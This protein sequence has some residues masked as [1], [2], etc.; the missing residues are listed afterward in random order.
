M[1][2]FHGDPT[3]PLS[4]NM[5][6]VTPQTRIDAYKVFL[7]PTAAVSSHLPLSPLPPPVVHL[8]L[9]QSPAWRLLPPLLLSFF[10]HRFS[11]YSPSLCVS[12]SLPRNLA[13]YPLYSPFDIIILFLQHLYL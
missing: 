8:S 6:V 4:Q 5:G 9:L 13:F 2:I 7:L 10:V 11:S 1:I 12:S 3:T